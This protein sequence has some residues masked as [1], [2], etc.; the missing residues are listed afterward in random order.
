MNQWNRT[1][2]TEIN[3]Y[4]HGQK[5]L[6]KD[7]KAAQWGKDTASTSITSKTGLSTCKKLDSYPIPKLTQNGIKT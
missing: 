4:V 7:V 6:D 1:E 3:P 5:N 2:I